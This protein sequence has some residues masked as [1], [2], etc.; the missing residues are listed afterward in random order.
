[1]R[2][3][4]WLRVA[5]GLATALGLAGCATNA[6]TGRRQL[7]LYSEAEEIRMGREAYEQTLAEIPAIADPALQA[8]VSGLGTKLAS[9]SERPGLPWTFTAVDDA[10]INAFALPGASSSSPAACSPI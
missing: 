7:N 5:L 9:K 3:G 4:R 1:M 8:Y 6:A 10:A 2:R